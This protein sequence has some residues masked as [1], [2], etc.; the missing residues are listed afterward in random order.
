MTPD[1]IIHR[2][3]NRAI[4]VMG[5]AILGLWTGFLLVYLRLTGVL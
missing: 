1:Q 5:V 4:A 2:F 3:L